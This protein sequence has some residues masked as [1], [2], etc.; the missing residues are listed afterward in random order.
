MLDYHGVYMANLRYPV[1]FS[2]LVSV[3]V[4]LRSYPYFLMAHP[5]G[6]LSSG[7]RLHWENNLGFVASDASS[8]TKPWIAITTVIITINPVI[9]QD[10]RIIRIPTILIM[11]CPF[12]CHR[13]CHSC[14]MYIYMLSFIRGLGY[15]CPGMSAPASMAVS[16]GYHLS[17]R[18]SLRGTPIMKR[19]LGWHSSR[20]F[21]HFW[22]SQTGDFLTNWSIGKLNWPKRGTDRH[23]RDACLRIWSNSCLHAGFKLIS[24]FILMPKS[25]SWPQ[26]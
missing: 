8:R 21:R 17:I 12:H 7:C 24:S 1:F 22:P 16:L 5:V 18:L 10:R 15:F 13:W 23:R 3:C 4:C 9:T 14:Y 2:Q 25:P 26:I 19:N 20:T 11:S 6:S